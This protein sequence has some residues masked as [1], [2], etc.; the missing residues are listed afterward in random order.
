MYWPDWEDECR[1]CGTTPCVIVE[2]H[3]QPHTQLCGPHF[4]HDHDM[5]DWTL[6]NDQDPPNQG[7]SE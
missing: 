5:T 6:W 4:F 3:V 1:L 7:D 2:G